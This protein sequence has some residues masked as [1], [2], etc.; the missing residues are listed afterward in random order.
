MQ[1][2]V[3]E[4]DARRG[5]ARRRHERAPR[6]RRG[7]RRRLAR[8][9]ADGARVHACIRIA[10]RRSAG[11]R[12]SARS[13]CPTSARSTG[14]GTRRTTR[15]SCA[16]ATSTSAALRDLIAQHYGAIPPAELPAPRDVVE[17]EQTR[18]RVVRAPKPIATDRLLVGYKAP[19]QDDPDWAALEIVVDAAR[20]L[21]VGAAVSP[22][23]DRARGGVVGRRAADA[24]PRSVAAAPRGHRPRAA[25]A[26]TRSSRRSIAS[27]RALVE[28]AADGAPRSRRPR[29]S[30]RPTSGRS[31][32]DVDGKAEALGHYETALGDFRKRQRRSPS[33]SPQ[34]TADDVARVVRDVPACRRAARS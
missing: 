13:R 21:P 34:V 25:T 17:P 3:L 23:R 9:A 6:A 16:S 19:G 22:A 33:G 20:R 15:R 18:E 10:G 29:R 11:W 28:T 14:R 5:R 26:P 31:L 4:P 2:L 8:R 30:P 27:S 1:H 7:R 32:V 24:V 12:T